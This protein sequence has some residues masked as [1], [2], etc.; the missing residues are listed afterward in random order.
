M[1]VI[2]NFPQNLMDMHHAWHSSS[3]HPPFPGRS[4]AP[5]Q[6]GSGLEFFQF[7][8][9][10]VVQFHAWYDGQPGADQNAVA[11]WTAI[12]AQL[13]V[14]AVGWNP[15]LA[16][17]E[18]RITTN[19]PPFATA[20]LLGQYV[21]DGIHN[22]IHGATASAFNEPSVADFHSPRSTYF[23]QIH[24]L[25]DYWWQQWRAPKS[26]FK[27]I[28]DTDP[29]RFI[30]DK[31]D[32]LVLAEGKRFQKD[33]I[34]EGKGQFKEIKEKDKDLVEN[35]GFDELVDPVVNPAIDPRAVQ[36]QDLSQRLERLE[37]FLTRP[38]FIRAEERP[39]V[40]GHV[41]DEEPGG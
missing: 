37:G 39:D 13:K 12:P 40:G 29:K 25:V 27:D 32:K 3:A 17:Q 4:I 15:N 5:G 36:F 10:F 23:F 22:W 20:D 24:G 7:H 28:I 6:P 19:S 9:D 21:E 30:D 38:S 2:P 18:Q 16:T 11:P 31:L 26:R 41:H 33:V 8:R 1:S 34:P 14:S 35:P